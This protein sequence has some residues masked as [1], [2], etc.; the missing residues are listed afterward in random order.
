MFSESEREREREREKLR[1]KLLPELSVKAR[2]GEKENEKRE[3]ER[4]MKVNVEWLDRGGESRKVRQVNSTESAVEM[5]SKSLSPNDSLTSGH[6]ICLLLHA[7]A[8]ILFIRIAGDALMA[9]PCILKQEKRTAK[10]KERIGVR[11]KK[12]E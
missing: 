11:G 12:D 1:E 8:H 4:E 3:R 9:Y 10:E 5:E 6:F 7:R 2:V